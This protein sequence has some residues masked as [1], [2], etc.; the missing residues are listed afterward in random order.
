L[1]GGFVRVGNG[2]A[3][4]LGEKEN[5]VR[6]RLREWYRGDWPKGPVPEAIAPRGGV[7]RKGRPTPS[8]GRMV[9][10]E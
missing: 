6:Q 8:V 7:Q 4:L 5:T 9:Q 1:K 10:D 3:E 2:G